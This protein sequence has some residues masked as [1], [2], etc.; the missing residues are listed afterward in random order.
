MDLPLEFQMRA[1][2]IAFS[3]PL[4]ACG[5]AG[6]NISSIGSSAS[7]GSAIPLTPSPTA[8]P[9][10]ST[11][12]SNLFDVST[13]TKFDAVGAVQSLAVKADGSSLYQG[14]ASTVQAPS[15]TISYDPRDGVFIMA[16][17]D[18]K[19]NISR[20]ITFQDPGH[21]TTADANN[22]ERQVPLLA[23]FNYLHVLD[24]TVPLTF[25]YQRPNSS[26]SFVSLAGFERSQMNDDGSSLAE[27]GVLVFGTRSATT[28]TPTKGAAHFDGQFLATMIAQQG[29]SARVQQWLN[30]VSAVDVDFA[31]RTLSL[32]LAGKVGP[33]F[34]QNQP[35]ADSALSVPSGSTFTATGSA[36]W[37]SAST[38]FAGKFAS[39][40]FSNNGTATPIDFTSVSAGTAAAG[41][42]SI[43]GTFYGPDA[44][45]VGGNFR[46]VGGIPNQRVDI[47]GGFVGVKK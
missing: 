1:V 4:A 46:I 27:Q 5:G 31:K 34:V 17:A 36:G 39:A 12:Q 9:T 8:T 19:A 38:A 28:Q 10:P 25:F 32:S 16:I 33:A 47:L 22:V 37:T 7:G 40:A 45:N 44:K 13:A 14:N 21:R 20:N 29:G 2:I 15:G 41:A 23:G 18:S 35:V 6:G 11:T 3:L 43:D 42:S 26:G 24:G 30:G